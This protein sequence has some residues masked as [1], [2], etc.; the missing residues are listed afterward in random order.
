MNGKIENEG[1]IRGYHRFTQIGARLFP[2]CENVR[3]PRKTIFVSPSQRGKPETP[4]SWCDFSLQD[5]D[6][7]LLMRHDCPEIG[8]GK[9]KG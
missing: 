8:E 6:S 1:F 5:T 7:E 4:E 3:H 9:A 2:V